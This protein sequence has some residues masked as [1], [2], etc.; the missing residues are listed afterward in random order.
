MRDDAQEYLVAQHPDKHSQS[1]DAQHRASCVFKSI[2]EAYEEL[3][4]PVKRIMYVCKKD[5]D[6]CW[7]SSHASY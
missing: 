2:Q 7:L 1:K 5:D 6:V 3:S 4:E